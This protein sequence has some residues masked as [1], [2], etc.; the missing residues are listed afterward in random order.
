MKRVLE[1]ELMDDEQQSIAYAKA[2]FS[3]SNQWYVDHLI[4]DFSDH[5]QKVI[6]IGCGPAGVLINLARAKPDIRITAIDGSGPMLKLAQQAVQMAGLQK[7][8]SPVQGYVPGLPLEEQSYDAVISKDFLHHLPDPSALWNE[9]KRLSKPGAAVYVMDL[10]RP[11]TPDDARR[12]VETVSGN[13]DPILKRD[14]FNSL[15]AAFSVEE[16]EEQLKSADLDLQVAPI[17]ERQMLIKGL[18]H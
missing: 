4:M 3:A 15:C 10:F 18:L 11:P 17:S 6:D 7:Q 9:A 16:I 5:L 2:D 13:E 1:P 14:F 12:I 8:I